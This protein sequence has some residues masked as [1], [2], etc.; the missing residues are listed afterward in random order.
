MRVKGIIAE[1]FVNYKTPAM[2]INTCFCDF[3]CCTD[4]GLDKGV[5]QNAPL[6]RA[7]VKEIADEVIYRHFASNPITKAVVIGG[8]EPFLQ[9]PELRSLIEVFRKSGDQSA[10]IIYTGYTAD[11]V[12]EQVKRLSEFR[13][14]I[15]KFGRFRP[16]QTPHRDEVLGVNLASDNQYAVQIS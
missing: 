14:I 10:F 3:K 13:N 16:N 8:L 1:D 6:A 11:E 9:F 4:I 7:E 12:A 2:F 5:C 15:I